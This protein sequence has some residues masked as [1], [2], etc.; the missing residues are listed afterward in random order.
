MKF[1]MNVIYIYMYKQYIFL[2]FLIYWRGIGE[3][4]ERKNDG[5]GVMKKVGTEK[6]N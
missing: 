6:G 5:G 1:K 2:D 4:G 3:I